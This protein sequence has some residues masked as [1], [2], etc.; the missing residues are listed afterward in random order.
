MKVVTAA[1][2]STFIG[3]LKENHQQGF[4]NCTDAQYANEHFRAVLSKTDS[5]DYKKTLDSITGDELNADEIMSILNKLAGV[6]EVEF[7]VI[8]V[9]VVKVDIQ[10]ETQTDVKEKPVKVARAATNTRSKK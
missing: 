8:P 10:E 9:E 6:V 2:F 4:S 5:A 7:K 3:Q 1:T